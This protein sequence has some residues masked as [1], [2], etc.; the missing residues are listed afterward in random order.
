[1]QAEKNLLYMLSEQGESMV[2]LGGKIEHVV[3]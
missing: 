3:G 2:N 1:M